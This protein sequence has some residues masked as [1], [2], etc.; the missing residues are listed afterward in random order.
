MTL[1][2]KANKDGGGLRYVRFFP[3]GACDFAEV[4]IEKPDGGEWSVEIEGGL[5]RIEVNSP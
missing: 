2:A 3:G 1:D 5:G 4:S